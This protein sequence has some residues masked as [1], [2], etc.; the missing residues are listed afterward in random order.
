MAKI[1]IWPDL[2]KEH[3][4]WMP[5]INL[6]KSLI[7]ASHTVEFMG[8][9]DCKSIVEPYN[10]VFNEILGTVYPLGYSLENKMEP[11]GQ[12]WKPEHLMEI[13][14]GALDSV[15][16]T[17]SS[18]RPALLISGYFN[19]LET[20]MIYWKYNLPIMTITTYLRHPDDDPAMLAKTKLLYMSRAMSRAL[21]DSVMVGSETPDAA[22]GMSIEEFIKP[23]EDTKEMIP[24]ARE[25]DFYDADWKH[26]PNVEYVEPMIVRQYL[27]TPTGTPKPIGS[28]VDPGDK[29]VIFASSGSQVQDYENRA[30]AFFNALIAM[31]NTQGMSDYFLI[32][33]VGEKLYAEL[34]VD[35]GIDDDTGDFPS[36]VWV[37]P[38]ASQLEVLGKAVAVFTHGGLATIKE[39]IWTETPIVI[40]PHGKDQ[41]DNSL[42]IERNGLGVTAQQ[43][44]VT[45]Q[46]FRKLLTQV[47]ASTW[48]KGNVLKM[49]KVFET[50]ESK[51]AGLKLSIK[52]I[53]DKLAEL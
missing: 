36:N 51:A 18:H 21:I 3:G 41:L 8:I 25:F 24:C 34:Q 37:T 6:A 31:A 29:K 35:Y 38:W 52:A 20:L 47:T 2:Y 7:D 4:H 49:K 43:E 40:V 11:Q 1:M 39:S 32:L 44:G 19:A 46:N 26:G 16:A 50:E 23:L 12:R 13:S 14:R 27:S 45:P 48:I 5:C 28:S 17:S 9:P 22:V 42:R 53:N 10:G 30:K 15:L 33:A